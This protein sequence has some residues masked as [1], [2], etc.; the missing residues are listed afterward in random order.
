[1]FWH[2]PGYLDDRTVPTSIITKDVD[3]KRYKLPYFYEDARYEF[4]N[5]TDDLSETTDLLA[6]PIAPA[7]YEVARQM[8]F[9][10]RAWLDDQGALYPT[11]RATGAPVPPPT[12][13]PAEPPP[14]VINFQLGRA[15][16]TPDAASFQIEQ[17]NVTLNLAATGNAALLDW[18]NNGVGVNSGQDAGTG[19]EQRR[20]DGALPTPETIRFSFDADV[21]ITSMLI[22]S[23]TTTANESLILSFVS[24]VNPFDGLTGYSGNYTVGTNSLTFTPTVGTAPLLV[25]FGEAGQDDLVITAGTV[26]AITANPSTGGGILFDEIT[27]QLVAPTLEGDFNQDGQVNSADYV[28]W[29]KGI[30]PG[31]YESWRSSFGQSATGGGGGIAAVPEPASVFLVFTAATCW[32]VQLTRSRKHNLF[33]QFCTDR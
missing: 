32:L 20:I 2:F 13:L 4:F 21:A 14:I 11:V 17:N 1:V 8:S 15:P 18:N 30:V 29:R 27:V 12:A 19:T 22:G 10:L 9:D 33:G 25:A 6:A 5:L 3:G 31:T 16:E 24:G 7:A 23:I 26:L 28:A